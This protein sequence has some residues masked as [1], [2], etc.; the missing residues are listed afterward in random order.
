MFGNF[1]VKQVAESVGFMTKMLAQDYVG[2]EKEMAADRIATSWNGSQVT[3]E[4][5]KVIVRHGYTANFVF[6]F[7][8]TELPNSPVLRL[9]AQ[10]EG[11]YEI[12]KI[13]ADQTRVV[14][15]LDIGPGASV[16]KNVKKFLKYIEKDSGI[17]CAGGLP[18]TARSRIPKRITG[19][20]MGASMT[21]SIIVALADG[22]FEQEERNRLVETMSL[23]KDGLSSPQ[24]ILS[25]IEEHVGKVK[26]VGQEAWPAFMNTI[27]K[28]MPLEAKK[29]I[30]HAAGN[31]ALVDGTFSEEEMKVIGGIASWIEIGE[32]GFKEWRAEFDL[33]LKQEIILG[34]LDEPEG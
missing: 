1:L 2:L 8:T 16:G 14:A 34:H 11:E 29:V 26:E 32:S 24:E 22:K 33:T 9:I 7:Q 25:F 23:Y 30:L 27:A 15:M 13:L 18:D 5:D 12:V 4:P 3:L 31:M 20:L 19:N 6:I 28:D 10:G 21:A 17:L